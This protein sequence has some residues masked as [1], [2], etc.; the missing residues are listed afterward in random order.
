MTELEI[1]DALYSG[2]NEL[3]KIRTSKIQIRFLERQFKKIKQNLYEQE[4]AIIREM[5]RNSMKQYR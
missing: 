1:Y 2:K 5:T 4:K 3:E